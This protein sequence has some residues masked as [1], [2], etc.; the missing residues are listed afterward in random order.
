MLTGLSVK[1]WKKGVREKRAESKANIC[2]MLG[3][4]E[5]SNKHTT[6]LNLGDTNLTNKQHENISTRLYVIILVGPRSK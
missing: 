3:Y 2:Q 4:S 1:S 6:I 5:M